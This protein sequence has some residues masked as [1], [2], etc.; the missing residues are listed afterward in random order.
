MGARVIYNIKQGDGN[1]IHLYSHWGETDRYPDLAKALDKARPRWTDE[2]YCARII[3]SQLIGPL[4][5]D[6][7]GFGLWTSDAPCYDETSM[8]I[9]LSKQ[10]VI[11]ETGSHSWE[12]FIDYHSVDK[13]LHTVV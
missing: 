12:G 13:D 3:V 5:S 1:Y 11:D 6:E 8:E 7:T 9:D 2:S 10:L 4:W